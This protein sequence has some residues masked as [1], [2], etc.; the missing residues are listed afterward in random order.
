MAS[1]PPGKNN[2]DSAEKKDNEAINN[3]ALKF[4]SVG[5][6]KSEWRRRRVQKPFSI[7]CLLSRSFCSKLGRAH[8]W[9]H[10]ELP[11]QLFT[12]S[13]IMFICSGSKEN[14][15]SLFGNNKYLVCFL[16]PLFA[17]ESLGL[18]LIVFTNGMKLPGNEWKNPGICR[19]H[20]NINGARVSNY[21]TLQ[22]FLSTEMSGCV[23]FC[24]WKFT[25]SRL[26]H[27]KGKIDVIDCA[28]EFILCHAKKWK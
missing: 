23:I 2:E 4:V 24:G 13:F 18:A 14:R 12:L 17:C 21:G 22:H 25:L 28:L 6:A 16:S 5:W 7:F 1:M 15:V 8:A 3:F 10:P 11:S 19:L 20:S 26:L 27:S 9:N